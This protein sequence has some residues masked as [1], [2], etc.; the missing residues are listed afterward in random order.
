M[1]DPSLT[2]EQALRAAVAHLDGGV[3]QYQIAFLYGVNQ[4]R[5][6]EACK[7][8]RIAASNPKLAM[9]VLLGSGKFTDDK[10]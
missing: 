6:A 8:L 3:D 1:S 5:V 2:R 4:G 10:E 9:E 7:G